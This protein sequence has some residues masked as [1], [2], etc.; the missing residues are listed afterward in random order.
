M[1]HVS[2]SKTRQEAEMAPR[3]TPSQEGRGGEGRRGGLGGGWVGRRRGD[4]EY[5]VFEILVI[6]NFQFYV[7]NIVQSPLFD[8]VIAIE[9]INTTATSKQRR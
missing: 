5:P 6:S 1:S 9:A 8:I 3:C 4:T 7:K 2:R